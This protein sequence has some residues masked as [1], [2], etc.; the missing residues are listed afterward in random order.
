[1]AGQGLLTVCTVKAF[2]VKW[3]I[4]V[5]DATL[6]NYLDTLGT[7]CCEVVLIAWHTKDLVIFWD[8]ALASD[9]SVAGGAK[10]A[11]LVKLLSFV[12]HFLHS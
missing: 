6:R 1:M 10:K 7:L 12:F 8:E 5:S 9:R 11:I 2:A 4:F 3:H